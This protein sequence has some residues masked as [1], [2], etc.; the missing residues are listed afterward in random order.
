MGTKLRFTVPLVAIASAC[1]VAPGC[2]CSHPDLVECTG[3]TCVGPKS[4]HEVA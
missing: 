1:A 3:P 2:N 4:E